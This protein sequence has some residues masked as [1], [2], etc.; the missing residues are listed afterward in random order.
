MQGKYIILEKPNTH[1]KVKYLPKTWGK[2][3]EMTLTMMPC[4]SNDN[5]PLEA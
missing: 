1:V 4:E 2:C 5:V 3:Y